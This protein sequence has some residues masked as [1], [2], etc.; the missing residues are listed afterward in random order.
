MEVVIGVEVRKST[1]FQLPRTECCKTG[2]TGTGTTRWL[3]L[4]LAFKTVLLAMV[5]T[6]I[7]Y[8]V[9]LEISSTLRTEA[10]D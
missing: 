1:S 4:L 6:L 2:L 9:T 10:E 7:F 5:G 3:I 8:D